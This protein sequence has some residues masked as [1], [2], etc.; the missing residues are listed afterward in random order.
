MQWFLLALTFIV[1]FWLLSGHPSSGGRPSASSGKAEWIDPNDAHQM[2][3]LI[4]LT[5]GSI[6]DV[7]VAQF[8]LRRFEEIHGRRATTA[9]I[10]TV[11]GLMRSL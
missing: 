2:G 4:G 11:V 9:D 10:G 3:L 6:A 5:G 8:A 1:F 7:A